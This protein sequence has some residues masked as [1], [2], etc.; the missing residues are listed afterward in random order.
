VADVIGALVWQPSMN[1]GEKDATRDDSAGTLLGVC[2]CGGE[3]HKACSIESSHCRGDDEVIYGGSH[4][5]I[6]LRD[7]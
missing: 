6:R 7:T 5:A 2:N 3:K 1:A 4:G